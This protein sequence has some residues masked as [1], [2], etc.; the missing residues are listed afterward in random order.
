MKQPMGGLCPPLTSIRDTI[1]VVCFLD[2]LVI[3]VYLA[4]EVDEPTEATSAPEHDGENEHEDEPE[5]CGFH[6]RMPADFGPW[7]LNTMVLGG[8]F[9]DASTKAASELFPAYTNG[10]IS[11][12]RNTLQYL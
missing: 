11:S 8:K 4:E 10:A 9:S 12:T 6:L 2:S 5:E 1:V 3:T 7:T